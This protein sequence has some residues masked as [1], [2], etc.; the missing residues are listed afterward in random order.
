MNV[1]VACGAYEGSMAKGK[2]EN[3][4]EERNSDKMRNKIP[5]RPLF[6]DG[7]CKGPE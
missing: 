2:F 6:F 7:H 1:C 4:D 5:H 3:L